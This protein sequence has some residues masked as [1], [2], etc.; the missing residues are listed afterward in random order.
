MS[1]NATILA[2]L[3]DPQ[4]PTPRGPGRPSKYA[5]E[6]GRKICERVVNGELVRDICKEDGYP[7]RTTVFNWLCDHEDF[8]RDYAIAR[9][10]LIE[11]VADE[12]IKIVDDSSNDYT[13]DKSGDVPVMMPNKEH[14]SRTKMRVEQRWKWL[15]KMAPKK[16]GDQPLLEPPPSTGDNAK[17]ISDDKMLRRIEDDP[18]YPED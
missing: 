7:C 6:I 11:D 8:R 13:L 2:A 18:L 14:L 4:V 12:I 5:P 1:D 9:H 17:V 10:C 3:S 15:A 16:Y